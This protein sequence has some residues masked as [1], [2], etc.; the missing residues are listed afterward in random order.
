MAEENV[1]GSIVVQLRAQIDGLQKGLTQAK[2]T[3]TQFGKSVQT[4][5]TG[6]AQGGQQMTQS[7]ERM[8][9]GQ[10]RLAARTALMVSRLLTLQ[11]VIQQVGTRF[12][13]SR[14]SKEV[15]VASDALTT[16]GAIVS[17]FPNKIGLAVGALAGIGTVFLNMVG[18]TRAEKK[19]LEELTEKLE[20]FK[21]SLLDLEERG[22]RAGLDFFLR[23]ELG[24]GQEDPQG[25]LL[26]KREDELERLLEKLNVAQR[27][28]DLNVKGGIGQIPLTSQQ[29]ADLRS[30]VHD[31]EEAIKSLNA[32]VEQGRL[33]KKFREAAKEFHDFNADITSAQRNLKQALT[34]G[35]ITPLDEVRGQLQLAERELAGLL[36]LRDKL[37]KVKPGAGDIAFGTNI[38][39]AMEEARKAKT[40]AERA[41]EVDRLA[42]NF[43]SAIG[44]GIVDGILAGESA[45]ETLANVSRNLFE[46]A[47]RDVVST[48]QTGM[49]SAFKAITGI[50]GVELGGLITGLVGI[51]AGIFAHRQSKAGETFSN[52]KSNI[53]SSQAVRGIVAGPANVA[54][55]S[56]GED[57]S[58]AMAPVLEVL[59]ASLFMQAK[60]ESNTRGGAVAGGGGSQ[61]LV[62]VPTA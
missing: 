52:V 41:G 25:N 22:A 50:A 8:E 16:F 51:A 24:V 62:G 35:L 40:Q 7:F 13:G 32:Q 45:M 38:A 11:L 2:A 53:E 29:L 42:N 9:R 19:A 5:A 12:A 36:D 33:D 49:T 18:P 4:V 14:F 44:Q 55:A 46:N 54:I 10:S 1:A 20:A 47:L 3:L 43:S 6:V 48:F 21:K 37:N 31:T 30:E 57:I 34:F 59:R 58:R 15:Q 61:S 26:E 23:K 39:T 28:L 56:V 17:V 60:I 27:R